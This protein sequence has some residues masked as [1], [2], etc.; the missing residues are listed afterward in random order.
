MAA[1]SAGSE[2]GIARGEAAKAYGVMT[3]S[4][5]TGAM[6]ISPPLMIDDAGVRELSERPPVALD[7]C[8]AIA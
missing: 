8:A 1:V 5:A 4:L 3:R 6:H 7:D 2:M